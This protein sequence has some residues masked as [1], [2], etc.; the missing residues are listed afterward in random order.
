MEL[1]IRQSAKFKRDLKTARKRS[2]DMSQLN[3]IIEMLSKGIALPLKN[4]DHALLGR[5]EGFRECHVTPDWLLI[6]R[7]EQDMLVLYLFRTGTHSDLF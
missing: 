1:I 3:A 6:Y 5:Y 7:I 4:R 2:W